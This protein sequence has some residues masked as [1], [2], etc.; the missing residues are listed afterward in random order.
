MKLIKV[1]NDT[2]IIY[3]YSIK[4]LKDDNKNTSFSVNIPINVLNEYGVFE[5]I[6][7]PH[8]SN[9]YNNYTE[10][11]PIFDNGVWYECWVETPMSEN[12]IEE[13]K[14]TMWEY[15]RNQRNQRLSESDW[16]QLADAP[17]TSEKKKEW[18]VYRQSLRDIVNQKDPF[19]IV[20]PT[21]EI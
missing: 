1:N 3:P 2:S 4:Q 20:W 5:V 13:V 15:V 9:P 18:A 11:T 21:I 19:N 16:T 12:Q 17:L 10:T 7:V 6:E 14:S 8:S